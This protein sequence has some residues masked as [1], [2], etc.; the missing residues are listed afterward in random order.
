M[1]KITGSGDQ[2]R[3]VL[4]LSKEF[5]KKYE[6]EYAVR[7]E[8]DE[9]YNDYNTPGSFN[10]KFKFPVEAQNYTKE[11]LESFLKT[12]KSFLNIGELIQMSSSRT[13]LSTDEVIDQ[14]LFL[15]QTYLVDVIK[16]QRDSYRRERFKENGKLLLELMRFPF[17][18]IGIDN[19]CDYITD[20]WYDDDRDAEL[21]A[22]IYMVTGENENIFFKKHRLV[23]SLVPKKTKKKVLERL[24][25]DKNIKIEID[26]LVVDKET[27]IETI[28]K[29]DLI[30]S[31]DIV[32]KFHSKVKDSGHSSKEAISDSQN[33]E[34]LEILI[35]A[36]Y[37][38]QRTENTKFYQELT[39][40]EM[41]KGIDFKALS[42][43]LDLKSVESHSSDL[44]RL[45]GLLM[46]YLTTEKLIVASRGEIS[47][48]HH[49]FIYKYLLLLNLLWNKGA[50][51]T[52][53][54]NK[55]DLNAIINEKYKER[56]RKDRES[57]TLDK[58]FYVRYF[59]DTFRHVT[60]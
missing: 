47:Y 15:S 24:K 46:Q 5:I 29:Q 59:R 27:G 43:T 44:K 45:H 37:E 14:L 1:A 4:K 26:K 41:S 40:Q 13:M 50:K 53:I 9:Y 17:P 42:D 31:R 18:K 38:E 19:L 32:V 16:K 3:L 54:N 7:D 8:F 33:R 55:N 12:F 58:P 52:P 2:Y 60:D 57:I 39:R 36:F 10:Y 20:A 30:I 21:G 35:K 28:G 51:P 34:M 11:Y 48:T 49:N 6:L 22:Y 23:W 56:N 25:I